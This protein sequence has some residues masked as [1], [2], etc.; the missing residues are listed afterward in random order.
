MNRRF[1]IV[2]RGGVRDGFHQ[3][4]VRAL[5]LSRLKVNERQADRL[6]SGTPVVLKR[7]LDEP[8]GRTYLRQLQKL[9]MDA[10]LEQMLHTKPDTKPAA[11]P[12]PTPSS[13]R[14]PVAWATDSGFAD[15]ERTQLNL[16]RAEALLGGQVH[17]D[18]PKIVKPVP[19]PAEPAPQ[20]RPAATPFPAQTTSPAHPP[21]SLSGSFVCSH[22]GVT[23]HI[24]AQVQ[25]S[26]TPT[27]A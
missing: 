25:I 27:S 20:A 22:C 1:Q 13:A 8:G 14:K 9:G 15:F 17:E 3:E 21:L 7:D 4:Q 11:P 2:F 18:T 16:A 19:K 5:A 26:S 23:H 12:A 24:S 6:F 10:V